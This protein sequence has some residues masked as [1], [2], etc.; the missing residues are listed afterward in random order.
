M[1]KPSFAELMRGVGRRLA[2]LAACLGDSA[3]VKQAVM[4]E[5]VQ[6]AMRYY[7]REEVTQWLV[8][9]GLA[10]KKGDTKASRVGGKVREYL[11]DGRYVIDGVV[12]GEPKDLIARDFAVVE[13]M[14]EKDPPPK[15]GVLH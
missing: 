13:P 2:D 8:S 10:P 4:R 6:E 3:E 9:V 11:P 15:G 12:F 1:S 7:S 5:F 14:R